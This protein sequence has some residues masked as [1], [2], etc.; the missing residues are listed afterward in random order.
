MREVGEKRI[1]RGDD[2][3]GKVRGD[4]WMWELVIDVGMIC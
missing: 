3:I 1:V 4:V 2:L